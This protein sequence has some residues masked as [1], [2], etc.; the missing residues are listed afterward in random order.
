VIASSDDTPKMSLSFISANNGRRLLH[1]P[2]D[3]KTITG[4]AYSR[5]SGQL[6]ALD[7]GDAEHDTG[8]LYQITA[9][10]R[11]G[12]QWGQAKRITT[13]AR[14]TAMAFAND[15]SLL[16]TLL[17]DRGDS[18]KRPTGQLIKFEPGL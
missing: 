2:A 9:I 12:K 5:K 7:F 17:G 3:L 8:G 13:L 4:L 15:G 16:V 11:D 1:V 14:P 10:W 6:F 18:E